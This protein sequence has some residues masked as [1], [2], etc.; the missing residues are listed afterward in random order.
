MS[1]SRSFERITKTDL[2]KLARI[3]ASERDDFF[4]RHPEWAMLYR[5]RL[6]CVA[7]CGDAALHFTN[8]TTGVERFEVWSFYAEHA[9]APYPHQ[10]TSR[11]DFGESKFG[12][13]AMNPDAY[14][15]RRVDLMGRSIDC[16]PGDDPIVSLQNY[17]RSGETPSARELREKSAVLIDPEEFTG[18]LA[19]PSLAMPG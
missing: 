19:W 17:L 2:K 12:R 5:K 13:D 7:L 11:A 9:E 14:E 15:G 6:V 4:G 10:Q 16:R 1:R 18:Y 8:G 3:A